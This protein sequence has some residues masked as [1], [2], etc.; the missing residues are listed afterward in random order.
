MDVQA[1]HTVVTGTPATWLVICGVLGMIVIAYSALKSTRWLPVVLLVVGGGFLLTMFGSRQAHMRTAENAQVRAQL[2]VEELTRL[3]DELQ[4]PLIDLGGDGKNTKDSDQTESDD[5]QS[6]A[7]GSQ[8][9]KRPAWVD[10]PS[11]HVG[12]VYRRVIVSNP[13]ETV[14]ACLKSLQQDK[15]R[16]ALNER[17]DEL[18]PNRY[19]PDLE[20]LGLGPAVMWRD[21]CHNHW[22]ETLELGVGDMKRVYGLVEFNAAADR[23]LTKA[24]QDY[25]RQFRVREVGGVAGIGLGSLA[26]LFGLLKV[27]TWTK[28]YYTKRLF[29]GVPAVI[30]GFLFML[31]AA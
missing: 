8:S 16:E 26:L 1:T 17:L 5:A 3:I 20:S 19:R 13:H 12:N 28:G 27:D 22:V 2:E 25:E 11:K 18:A 23:Q 6:V 14:E 7:A 24:Y 15:L 31:F 29:F 21:I 9:T 10:Q 4:K 30:I